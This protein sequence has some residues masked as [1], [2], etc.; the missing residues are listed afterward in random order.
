[1]SGIYIDED[2]VDRVIRYGTPFNG[3][4]HDL[5]GSLT[6]LGPGSWATHFEASHNVPEC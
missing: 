5:D 6:G 2:S 3:I 4:F 1:V